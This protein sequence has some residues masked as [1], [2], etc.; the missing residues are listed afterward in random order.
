[1]SEKG[2]NSVFELIKNGTPRAEDV[3]QWQK[4]FDPQHWEKT[5]F[6]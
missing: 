3:A 4:H 6:E 1:M 5:E 2:V